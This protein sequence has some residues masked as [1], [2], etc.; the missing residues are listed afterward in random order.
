MGTRTPCATLALSHGHPKPGALPGPSGQ[1]LVRALQPVGRGDL[2]LAPRAR[3]PLTSSRAFKRAGPRAGETRLWSSHFAGR[4][5]AS[6]LGQATAWKPLFPGAALGLGHISTG[7]QHQRQPEA[8]WLL[9]SD[10]E[11]RASPC[12]PLHTQIKDREVR[13]RS[14][15]E[16]RAVS[17]ARALGDFSLSWGWCLGEPAP[18]TCLVSSPAACAAAAYQSFSAFPGNPPF[19]SILPRSV[20]RPAG[21]RIAGC[22]GE[23][24]GTSGVVAASTRKELRAGDSPGDPLR[25][26]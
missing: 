26:D 7:S 5:K 8:R 14:P 19:G 3:L 11:P 20:P 15:A 21:E 12:L 25:R 18:A 23:R 13:P 22:A 6:L 9:A 10:S 24:R 4:E 2:A 16:H 1:H 17:R